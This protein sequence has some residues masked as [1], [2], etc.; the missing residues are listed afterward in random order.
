VIA[1]PTFD[2]VSERVLAQLRG[3]TIEQVPFPHLV[4]TEAFP[5]EYYKTIVENLPPATS[6]GRAAYPGT[7]SFTSR[8]GGQPTDSQGA[9]H[10]GRV[11]THWSVTPALAQLAS[12][13]SGEAFSRALLDRFSDPGSG[14]NGPAIPLAKHEVFAGTN[15]GYRCTYALHQDPP[16]YEIS[17]HVDNPAKIVTFLWYIDD[18]ANSPCGTLL[19]SPKPGVYASSLLTGDYAAAR[20]EGRPGLWMDWD[21]FDIVKEVCGPNVLLAFPPSDVS[22]HGVRIPAVRHAQ[23]AR[24][25][26]RGFIA[27]KGY[28]DITVIE[29]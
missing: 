29:S 27:R 26:V 25:V 1:V 12:F 20:R 19:C 6:F 17:P 23:Q 4:L 16:G 5:P 2:A 21:N 7:G 18:D 9:D 10:H 22:F 28:G 14:H 11:L 13:F 3:A 8:Y 24:T 15:R